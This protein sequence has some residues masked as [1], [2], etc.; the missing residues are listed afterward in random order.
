MDWLEIFLVITAIMGLPPAGL[1]ITRRHDPAAVVAVLVIGVLGAVALLA[2]AVALIFNGYVED[3]GSEPVQTLH[4][5][6]PLLAAGVSVSAAAWW[7]AAR[8]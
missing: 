5:A 3:T 8:A 6:I 1:A 4:I 7:I 2:G